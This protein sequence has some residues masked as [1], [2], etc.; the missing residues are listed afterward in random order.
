MRYSYVAEIR[1]RNSRRTLSHTIE[2]LYVDRR[3]R[4]RCQRHLCGPD[5]MDMAC[6]YWA[7]T[8]IMHNI[9]M[10]M[11]IAATVIYI[12]YFNYIEAIQSFFL[13]HLRFLR[14]CWNATCIN[15]MSINRSIRTPNISYHTWTFADQTASHQQS[16]LSSS[17]SF[18]KY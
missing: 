11:R 18:H 4:R 2:F 7:N 14:D 17:S 15:I 10:C 9:W 5:D 13:L 16:F 8:Y 3:C 1:N 6:G 12:I